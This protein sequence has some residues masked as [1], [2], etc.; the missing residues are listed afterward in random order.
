[1]A[2]EF[3]NND[4]PGA[5]YSQALG[6]RAGRLGVA[7]VPLL[8]PPSGNNSWRKIRPEASGDLRVG[9]YSEGSPAPMCYLTDWTACFR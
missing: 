2:L 8:V 7:Q 6:V 4:V 9:P 5:L 1:M 3:T